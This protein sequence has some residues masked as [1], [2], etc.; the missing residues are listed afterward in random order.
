MA[1]YLYLRKGFMKREIIVSLVV[2]IIGAAI[3]ITIVMALPNL[4]LN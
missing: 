4:F 2:G 1:L 3:V